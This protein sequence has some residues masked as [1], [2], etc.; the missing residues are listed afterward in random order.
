MAVAVYDSSPTMR[1]TI[2]G[3]RLHLVFFNLQLI[4]VFHFSSPFQLKWSI[5]QFWAALPR[6]WRVRIVR[7]HRAGGGV[8]GCGG[9]VIGW[10]GGYRVGGRR[11]PWV[12]T[13]E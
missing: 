8:I 12:V 4:V 3:N 6:L 1:R 10:G 2:C 7:R 11:R 5:L 13:Y 9:G